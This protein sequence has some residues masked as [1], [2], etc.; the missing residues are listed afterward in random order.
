VSSLFGRLLGLD[1]RRDF[2]GP[3]AS[4]GRIPPPSSVGSSSAGALVNET[5][6]MQLIDVYACVSLVADSIAML[7]AATYRKQGDFRTEVS[8]TVPIV[9]QPDPEIE[10]NEFWSRAAISV[11]LRGN[12]YAPITSRD[13]KGFARAC[14][15]LH[16]DD[17]KVQR[18]TK[19]HRKEFKLRNG[20]VISAFDM[21]H[22]PWL[23]MPGHLEG[24]NTLEAARRGLGLSIAT[25]NFG[26]NWFRDG[27]SPSSVLETEQELNAKQAKQAL[28]QWM[29]TNGGRRKPAVL[30]GGFKWRP[31]TITP[32]ESQFLE[33]RKYNTSQIA[34]LFRVP[35]HMI[36][37]VEKSTSWGSGL[38]EQGI[39]YVVFT[40]GSHLSRLESAWSR[41]LPRP[42]YMK[43]KPGALLRGNTKDRYLSYAVARQWGWLSVNDIRALEDLPP[44][45]GGD[46]YLQ[47]LNMIDAGEA[48]KALA[49]SAGAKRMADLADRL[50]QFLPA[51]A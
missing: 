47:P 31:V 26:A 3:W 17:V 42:Q 28:A 45:D 43:F 14:T 51:A 37:D 50:Q 38:E 35:P 18:N 16:P 11:L 32:N 9:D 7:P 23:T 12:L 41:Q 2:S 36:G 49:D 24:M 25:E 48:M 19:T 4:D 8:G 22:V 46:I 10:P 33:T 5:T 40:L 21:I 1:E 34:R 39:G 30:S 20:D 15:I 6:A 13:A 27:A 44:V 29:A